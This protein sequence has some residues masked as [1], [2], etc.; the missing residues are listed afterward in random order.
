LSMRR[1]IRLFACSYSEYFLSIRPKISFSMRIRMFPPLIRSPAVS[2][3]SL[4]RKNL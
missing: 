1:F 4:A 3:L 2:E